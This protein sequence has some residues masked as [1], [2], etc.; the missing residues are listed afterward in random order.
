M[1]RAVCKLD[2][3]RHVS[4]VTLALALL[5]CSATDDAEAPVPSAPD[6]APANGAAQRLAGAIRIPTISHADSASFDAA[7]FAALHEYLKQQ[8]PRVHAELQRETI[9]THS[10]LYTWRGSDPSLKPI[11]LMAHQDVVPVEPGTESQWEQPAFAGTIANGFVWGRGAIDNK[12]AV[13]GILESIE[14]LLAEGYRPTRTVLLAFGH[15]E[16]VGGRLGARVMAELLKQRGTRLELVLDEGGIVGDGV[17]PG[18]AAPTALVGVAEKG[19]VSVEL[20]ARAQGGHSSLP[21]RQSA[22]GILS[23]AIVRIEENPM[24]ARIHGA[25]QQL[26]E[27]LAPHSPTAQRA[28][29]SNLWLTRPLVMRKLQAS[30]STNAMV[31]TTTAVTIFQG[32]TKENVLPRQARAVINFRILPGDSIGDVV[33]HVRRVVDDPRV[34][35]AIAP[36]FSAEPSGVSNTESHSYRIIERTVRSLAPEMIVAPYLVV[37]V[38]DARYFAGLTDNVLRFLP[39]R[40][41]PVDLARMHGLNERIA[42]RDY[43]WAIRFYRQLIVNATS[44]NSS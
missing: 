37:V 8:F 2:L 27:A 35:V 24:P 15:D 41:Q 42:I 19:F 36:G 5:A 32:G 1:A 11:L 16:E 30:P 31:R 40:L 34:A 3:M 43:E 14:M 26:F 21:P 4:H 39:V 6:V 9:A 20:I 17:M 33:A 22:I 44:E 23:A 25:T 12:S 18:L 38:T 13:V 29:F 10:L 28:I 7:A